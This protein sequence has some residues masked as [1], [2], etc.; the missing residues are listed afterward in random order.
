MG[1]MKIENATRIF[2][3]CEVTAVCLSC[4]LL[5]RVC[6][7]SINYQWHVHSSGFAGSDL[8]NKYEYFAI[9]TGQMQMPNHRKTSA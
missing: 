1:E 8:A 9:S 3:L 5:P 4:Q 7:Q 2:G 6:L